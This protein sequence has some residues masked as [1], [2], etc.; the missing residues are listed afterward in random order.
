MSVS[1]NPT[2]PPFNRDPSAIS[3]VI[4][5]KNGN[6]RVFTIDP[7]FLPQADFYDPYIHRSLKCSY[8]RDHC[9]LLLL[10]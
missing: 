1:S 9:S 5:R 3:S 2:D 4:F 8:T 10:N 7:P 6:G